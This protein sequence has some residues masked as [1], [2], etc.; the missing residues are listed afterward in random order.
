LSWALVNASFL[1]LLLRFGLF[2]AVAGIFVSRF[3][4]TFPVTFDFSAW[5]IGASL[6]ALVAVL[7]LAVYGF[8]TALAGRPLL[9]DRLLEA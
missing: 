1:F 7:A 4:V 2:A 5:Y 3:F 6:T 9:K 8:H